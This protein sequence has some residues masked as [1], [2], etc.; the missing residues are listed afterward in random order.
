MLN[1]T[2]SEG[3]ELIF[4][5]VVLCRADTNHQGHADWADNIRL[6]RRVFITINES[7]YALR[8]S[9]IKPGDVRCAR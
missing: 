3:N 8:I 7:D 9:R 4:D 6:D 1:S 2:I 5:N